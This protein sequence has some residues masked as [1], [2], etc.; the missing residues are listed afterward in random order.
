MGEPSKLLLIRHA[1]ELVHVTF[2]NLYC[3]EILNGSYGDLHMGLWYGY[4]VSV[5]KQPAAVAQCGPWV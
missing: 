3:Y 1:F 5:K 4:R 2:R